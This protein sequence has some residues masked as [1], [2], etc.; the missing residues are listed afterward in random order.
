MSS[1]LRGDSKEKCHLRDCRRSGHCSYALYFCEGNILQ[2]VLA[3]IN[4]GVLPCSI[5]HFAGCCRGRGERDTDMA[6]PYG[7][8]AHTQMYKGCAVLS[9]GVFAKPPTSLLISLGIS[10]RKALLNMGKV[11]DRV[12]SLADSVHLLSLEKTWALLWWGWWVAYVQ[13]AV[14]FHPFLS[15][16]SFLMVW[17]LLW[18]M[19]RWQGLAGWAEFTALGSCSLSSPQRKAAGWIAENTWMQAFGPSHLILLLQKWQQIHLYWLTAQ[20]LVLTVNVRGTTCSGCSILTKLC[21]ACPSSLFF[22]LEA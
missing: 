19:C 20:S 14:S 1:D 10:T 13:E 11:C 16:P 8:A 17:E 21:V 22:F 2:L 7:Q 12:L 18:R 4:Y 3:L 9:A 15:L 5:L 6:F